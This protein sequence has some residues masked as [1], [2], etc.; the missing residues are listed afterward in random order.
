MSYYFSDWSVDS[1]NLEKAM[2]KV[3]VYEVVKVTDEGESCY[4]QIEVTPPKKRKS[5]AQEDN[6]EK[7]KK[8]R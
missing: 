7:P 8:P 1:R 3:K 6:V 5:K 2:E 4:N